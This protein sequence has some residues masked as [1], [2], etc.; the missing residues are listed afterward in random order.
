M[1]VNNFIP[2]VWAARVLENLNK[3]LVYGQPGVVN[4]DYE[5]DIR[6][7]GDQVHIHSIGPVT[8]ANYAK[9]TTTVAYEVLNDSRQTL[10]I[11]QSKYFAF[12][13]DDVDKAQTRPKVI[14]A[15]TREASYGLAEVADRFLASQYANAGLVQPGATT[16][17]TLTTANVYTELLTAATT[18]DENNVPEEGRYAI[19]PPWV[20]ALLLDNDRFLQAKKDAVLNG[21]IGS[22]A[23]LRILKSNNVP[24]TGTTTIV[25]H[26][27]VGHRS[28]ISYAEQIAQVE[29]IRLQGSFADGVRGL[30]LY[31]AKVVRPN[32]L[33]NL[34]V[35]R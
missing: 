20:A 15:G 24:T 23:G 5:G 22:V 29:A 25:D 8:V 32:A 18:L 31:G 27:L 16:Q 9:N 21:E 17:T 12:Q 28:A 11:D 2:Q 30:H 3:N 7:A 10:L 19:V 34:R 1:A 35:T 6:D 14:D 26:I 13:V 4:K 33:L